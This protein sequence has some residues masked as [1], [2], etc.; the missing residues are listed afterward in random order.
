MSDKI[1]DILKAI[2]DDSKLLDRLVREP[3]A[4][5]KEFKLNRAESARLAHSDILIASAHNPLLEI[6]GWT[7]T[8]QTI[9]ITIT[10]NPQKNSGDP[11]PLTLEELSHER[12][13]AI[14][15]RIL[16]EP[17]YAARVRAFLRL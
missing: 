2:A 1:R 15:Q 14:A 16:V 13:V 10:K 6:A 9:H 11:N 7:W 12:L 4:V 8:A 5:A 17:D 3:K